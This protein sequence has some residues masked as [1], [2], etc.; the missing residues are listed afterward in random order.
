MRF[1]LILAAAFLA[2]P[3]HAQQPAATPA[4]PPAITASA[5]DVFV[6]PALYSGKTITITQCNMFNVKGDTANCGVMS[7][8]GKQVGNLMLNMSNADA[9][10]RRQLLTRCAGDEFD[11]DCVL[12]VVARISAKSYATLL[13]KAH[14]TFK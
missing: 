13:E 2:F 8:K 9:S 14:I 12:D 4:T 5:F 3:A 11:S 6:D 7:P 1:K 10:T